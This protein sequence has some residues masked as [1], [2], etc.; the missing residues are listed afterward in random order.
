M[1]DIKDAENWSCCKNFIEDDVSHFIPAAGR[2]MSEPEY[3]AWARQ[4][5]VTKGARAG[6]GTPELKRRATT[7][8]LAFL[9]VH[10]FAPQWTNLPFPAIPTV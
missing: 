1:F 2:A 10:G 3:Q 6:G 4:Y 9:H 7:D 5:C 8:L